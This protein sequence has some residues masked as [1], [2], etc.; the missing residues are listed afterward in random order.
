MGH[1]TRMVC[2]RDPSTLQPR[3]L[4]VNATGIV[5][6]GILYGIDPDT[7]QRRAFPITTAGAIIAGRDPDTGVS[8]VVPVNVDGVVISG[9]TQPIA[10]AVADVDA[11]AANT[12]AVVT[13][14]GVAGQSHIITGFSWSY[15]GGIPVGGNIQVADGV[16]VV[17]DIDIAEEGCG[18]FTFP[19]GK[20]GT[21]GA[22]MTITLAAGG[23][24]ITGKLSILGHYTA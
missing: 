8:R 11:P 23:A 9:G 13:Y 2:G 16:N 21:V 4:P 22:A 19:D 20:Q 10:A 6:D 3:I 15:Y 24:G 1:E 14:A 12:A 17:F 18:F 5:I 7:G